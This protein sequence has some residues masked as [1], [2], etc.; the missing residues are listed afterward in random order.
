M[1]EQS[2]FIS[3]LSELDSVNGVDSKS[4]HSAFGGL[5]TEAFVHVSPEK[6]DSLTFAAS[7]DI[8]R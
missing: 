4:A 1:D 2:S 6:L 3:P 7:F 5:V 8:L